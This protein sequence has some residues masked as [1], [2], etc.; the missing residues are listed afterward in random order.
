MHK[1][2]YPYLPRWPELEHCGAHLRH[3]HSACSHSIRG[4]IHSSYEPQSVEEF[5][6]QFLLVAVVVVCAIESVYPREPEPGE[7]WATRTGCQTVPV[8]I[9]NYF[10]STQQASGMRSRVLQARS[11]R[12]A[13]NDEFR[14]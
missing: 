4:H 9:R 8:R 13:L 5:G 12:D 7:A 14:V 2:A 6:V 1:Q 11:C 10:S 3:A